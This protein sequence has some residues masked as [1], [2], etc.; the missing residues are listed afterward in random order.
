[1]WASSC[2]HDVCVARYVEEARCLVYFHIFLV[3][4]F[5]FTFCPVFFFQFLFGRVAKIINE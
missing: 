1:M 4:F 2:D 3:S 5:S